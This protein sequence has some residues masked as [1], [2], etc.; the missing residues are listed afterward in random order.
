MAL[1]SRGVVGWVQAAVLGF[2]SLLSTLLGLEGRPLIAELSIGLLI[3]IPL[4]I[5]FSYWVRR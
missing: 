5:A 2:V 4:A 3:T 1:P